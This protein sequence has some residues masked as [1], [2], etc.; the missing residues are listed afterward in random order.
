MNGLFKK[1]FFLLEKL[2]SKPRIDGLTIHDGGFEYV[3]LEQQ[4]PHTVAVRLPPGVL[5]NGKL[6]N[7][8]QCLEALNRLH[9]AIVP[10]KPEQMLRATVVLPEGLVYTQSF[11]IPNV[12]EEKLEEAV[13]LNLQMISP[14]PI[15]E[16]NMSAQ[17]ISE[18]QDQ[19]ELMGAFTS[20]GAIMEFR[21]LLFEAHFIPV[22]FESPGFALA[23]LVKRLVKREMKL[24]L[25]FQVS[26]DGLS[27]YIMRDGVLYFSYFRSWQSV[28]GN[29]PSIP[30]EI[31]DA[32]VVQEVQK[33]INFSVSKF[34]EMPAEL[35]LIAGGFEKEI[36]ATLE[37]NF[38]F[39]IFPFVL[40]SYPAITQSFYPSLGA[41]LRNIEEERKKFYAIN[42]GG[43]DLSKT[44]KEEQILSF[45][46]LWRNIIVG[47][48]A[49]LLIAFGF[50]AAFLVHQSK[51]LT[52]QVSSFAVVSG[53]DYATLSE[54]ANEFN[55]LVDAIQ[56]V[57]G[58]VLP[59]QTL[60]AHLVSVM[61]SGGVT[62]QTIDVQSLYEPIRLG[63]IAPDFQTVIKFKNTVSS[64]PLFRNVD[65][66]LTQI[67]T[68]SD[69]SVSFNMTFQFASPH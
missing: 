20:R 63:A 31:F 61:E 50:S 45:I 24:I 67:V 35:W 43:E 40:G 49:I 17:V 26:S 51:L 55:K 1:I 52:Q 60:L 36:G 15:E 7:R 44:L 65:V 37:K 56:K 41:A 11:E 2:S 21:N 25:L 22:A 3:F 39:K 13:L 16:T 5:E 28:R 54:K 8:E 33:V 27:L 4:V 68:L 48:L 12:G 29:I 32:I 69:N 19:Y 53:R 58:S 42:L 10:D 46:V 34:G 66:P 9:A 64:D 6:K 47:V 14:M 38:S 62:L 59:W 30:R 57:K 18:T 23:R